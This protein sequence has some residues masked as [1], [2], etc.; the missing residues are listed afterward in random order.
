MVGLLF[1]LSSRSL[2]GAS[3]SGI[4]ITLPDSLQSPFDIMSAVTA[5]FSSW[6]LVMLEFSL[7]RFIRI[8]TISTAAVRRQIPE[9]MIVIGHMRLDFSDS[10]GSVGG[11]CIIGSS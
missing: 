10:G 5:T 6:I 9:T 3:L 7:S 8:I 4:S 11:G 1:I 2:D